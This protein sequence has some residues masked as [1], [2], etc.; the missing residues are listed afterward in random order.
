MNG[1]SVLFMI[2]TSVISF[3]I[4][5]ASYYGYTRYMKLRF[6][7]N[8][9]EYAKQY[10][11]LERANVN[12]KIVVSLYAS[13]T[14]SNDS[15]KRTIHSILDQTVKPDQIIINVA[16]DSTL[17][18]DDFL[19]S[20]N[21]ISIYKM[22]KDYGEIGS[23][24]SPLLIEKDAG[25]LIILAS[26]RVIYGIEF[27]EKMVET[28]IKHPDCLIYNRGFNAQ[29][30][31]SNKARV[32]SEPNNDIIDADYGVLVKPKFFPATIVDEDRFTTLDM[33]L[34]VY[35]KDKVCTKSTH[36]SEL[37]KSP[38]HPNID[39]DVKKNIQKNAIYFPGLTFG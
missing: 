4:I 23:L 38:S 39:E 24:I 32:D 21:I 11:K 25:A 15:M 9:I 29:Q 35:V 30:F 5:L 31:I 37:F 34:S 33:L 13:P 12:K 18:I 7:N 14:S 10:T 20:N 17:K 16:P 26:E 36:Y 6:E 8:T 1:K 27:V 2:V 3:V 22:G 28:S 19:I